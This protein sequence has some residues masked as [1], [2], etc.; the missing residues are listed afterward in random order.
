MKVFMSTHPPGLIF[1]SVYWDD[2][3]ERLR[4]G[5]VSIEDDQ[6]PPTYEITTRVKLKNALFAERE[7]GFL[8]KWLSSAFFPPTY[9]ISLAQERELQMTERDFG[10]VFPNQIINQPLRVQ[11]V[12]KEVFIYLDSLYFT[13]PSDV[14]DHSSTKLPRKFITIDSDKYQERPY[15]QLHLRT[16]DLQHDDTQ[17]N[18]RIKYFTYT[19]LPTAAEQAASLLSLG[20]ARVQTATN[21]AIETSQSVASATAQASQ[22]LVNSVQGWLPT[23]GDVRESCVVS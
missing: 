4:D 21:N 8:S 20:V 14:R 6:T 5:F 19:Q 3:K 15:I 16:R 9:P 11:D 18:N 7:D 12:S 23:V 13:N 10:V 22:S 1:L 17:E 2:Q